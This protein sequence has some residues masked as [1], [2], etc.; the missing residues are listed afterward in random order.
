MVKSV[1]VIP[2][3]KSQIIGIIR[4]SY[5]NPPA[6]GARIVTTILNNKS[7]FIEW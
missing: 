2:K 4:A 5:N 1:D 6:N 7:F 3:I